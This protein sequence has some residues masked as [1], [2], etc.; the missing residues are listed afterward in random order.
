MR[1]RARVSAEAQSP[2][3]RAVGEQPGDTM[4]RPSGSNA[5]AFC[6]GGLGCDVAQFHEG[7][8]DS[9]GGE[10]C[11]TLPI[12]SFLM[13]DKNFPRLH[14]L[15]SEVQGSPNDIPTFDAQS[16]TAMS[17]LKILHASL[18]V[19]MHS[20]VGLRDFILKSLERDPRAVQSHCK[21]R[22]I[23][24][25]PPPAWKWTGC[26][27]P[28]PRRRRLR[29][30]WQLRNS[31]VQ[32]IICTL[33]WEALGHIKVPPPAARVGAPLSID[34]LSMVERIE[35]MVTYFMR[36]GDFSASS[37]GRSA[38]KLSR[39][40]HACEELPAQV[41]DEDLEFLAT[42]V[43]SSV[44]PYAG[45]SKGE[46]DLNESDQNSCVKP[47]PPCQSKQIDIQI[48]TMAAK[49]VQADRIKWEHSPSFDP[50]PYLTDPI[51]KRAFEDP[52]C[53]K[54][55]ESLWIHRPVARVHCSRKEVLKLAEK[56]DSKSACRLFPADQID[57]DEAVGIF[58]VHKDSNFDRLILN[59]VVING[60]T[61]HYSN[62]TKSLAPGSMIGLV[63]LADNEMLRISGDDL[64]EMYYTF[65]VPE[66]RA[67][68]NCLRVVFHHHEVQH[69]SCYDPSVHH[70]RKLYIALSALAMGDSLAVE[71]AQQAHHQVLFQLAGAMRDDERV[72]YRRCFPRGPFFELLAIDDHIG[73]QVVTVEDFKNQKPAR[74]TEVFK[75][76]ELAYRQVG[77][78]QHQKK[79]RRCVT[80]GVFLGSEVDGR[81]GRVSA[82]RNRVL[83]LM[84]CTSVIAMKGAATRRLLSCVLGCWI[85][86]LMFRRPIMSILSAVF[87]EG[88]H[89]KQDVVFEL[90]RQSRNELMAL[91]ILGP[92]I[93]T[94]LRTTTCPHI[95]CLDASPYGAGIC[96]APESAAVVSELWRNSEQNRC[97]LE[98]NRLGGSC[99]FR[100]RSRSTDRAYS[101]PPS[102]APS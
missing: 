48:D 75:R 52:S 68:R 78:V 43:N 24:P 50:R 54:L 71:I 15:D 30:F 76:A 51:V 37:L 23:W 18:K 41:Q 69:M 70:G 42:F 25:C 21:M 92:V 38:D 47:A 11:E 13:D 85:H 59:P 77:L 74:D 6:E 17:F 32:Q 1:S 102:Q 57:H 55:P 80:E 9:R 73:L 98:R 33:N 88:Q 100:R 81:V 40:L 58:A 4:S 34:Q 84:L 3:L 91:T 29:R 53:M 45:P 66:T 20:H 7:C 5:G 79:K 39:I 22:D 8:L 16:D 61:R 27:K 14:C 31:V 101:F 35:G 62:Y 49:P 83:I 44:D 93:Q 2:A 12:D 36:A 87:S 95:F 10:V 89:L 99:F 97:N 56:W 65:R 96:Q 90:G 19:N 94:N 26:N 86:I 64:A 72:C 28:S 60:K 82:P 67:R 63:Q 46:C